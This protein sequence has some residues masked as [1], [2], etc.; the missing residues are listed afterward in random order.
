MY[1]TDYYNSIY[2]GHIDHFLDDIFDNVKGGEEVRGL[3]P[4]S[5]EKETDLIIVPSYVYDKLIAEKTSYLVD[6]CND[7]W[8]RKKVGDFVYIKSDVKMEKNDKKR[9]KI[10]SIKKDKKIKNII[11]DDLKNIL[12]KNITE[13]NGIKFITKN[14]IGDPCKNFILVQLVLDENK[15]DSN[16]FGGKS[17]SSSSSSSSSD[18]DD[19]DKNN[20]N[21]GTKIQI[22][23]DDKDNIKSSSSSDSETEK[24]TSRF[25]GRN[26]N[27]SDS[28]TEK[29]TFGETKDSSSSSDS[30]TEKTTSRFG[31]RNINNYKIRKNNYS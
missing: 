31:R 7:F 29:T 15:S 8:E 6:Y 30:E 1:F 2:G 18:S 10:V 28:E 3:S 17:S 4:E 19:D 23:N 5:V 21:F 20:Y 13:K 27:K 16:T 25:G 14:L 24:T 12:P 26:I 9:T 22:D 11:K